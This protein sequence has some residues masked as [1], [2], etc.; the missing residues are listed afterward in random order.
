MYLLAERN[1]A[2]GGMFSDEIN[3]GLVSGVKEKE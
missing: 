1:V 2:G 3:Q